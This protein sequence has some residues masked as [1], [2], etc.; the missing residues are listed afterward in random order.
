MPGPILPATRTPTPTPIVF[1]METRDPDDVFTLCALATHPW[2]RLVAVTVTPGS[3]EQIGVVKHVL[4]RL[5]VDVPVGAYRP[6]RQAG[7]VSPFHEQWLG[8]VPSQ[9]PD[10]QGWRLLRET[11]AA[12]TTLLTGGPPHNPGALL[13]EEPGFA[14]TRW[15]AQGGFAGEPVVPPERQLPKFQGRRTCATFNFGGAPEA[16]LRLLA[17]PGIGRRVLV[18]KNV[19]HGVVYDAE[20]HVAVSARRLTAGLEAVREGMELYLRERPA[21]K[22]FH[23]P[24]AAAVALDEDVCGYAEVEV[25]RETGQW[26]ALPAAG[27]GTW[28]SVGVDR[29][30]FL[31]VLTAAS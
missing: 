7:S 1:D 24:L 20:M 5:G 3:D 9:K 4:R 10:E 2:A 16:A 29:E 27:S 12:G 17:T 25:Y 31:D 11:L 6:G 19:C 8:K 30:R 15:V 26:G 18:S 21:G 28:I 22:M 23:D 13:A 14:I